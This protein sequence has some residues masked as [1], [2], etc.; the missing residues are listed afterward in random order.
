MQ[1]IKT[2]NLIS[3]F[4]LLIPFFVLSQIKAI[5]SL[6]LELAL[7]IQKDSLRVN[8]LNNISDLTYKKDFDK[9]I[10]FTNESEAISKAIDYKKGEARSLHIRGLAHII[11]SKY[12]NGGEY[13]MEAL[14]LYKLINYKKG[15]SIV[16]NHLGVYYY[17]KRDFKEAIKYYSEFVKISKE[18]GND[19]SVIVGKLFIGRSYNEIGNYIDAIK[20]YKEALSLSKATNNK[21]RISHSLTSIG[22]VYSHQ[23]NYPLALE[24]HN[25][26]LNIAKKSENHNAICA[27]LMS[28]GNVYIRVENYD[29]AIVYHKEALKMASEHDKQN[30][31]S[32]FNN[33]GEAYMNKKN[34]KQARTYFEKALIK[35]KA[36]NN[37]PNIAI[38]LNN[39]GSIYLEQK[40]F[41]VANK[42]FEEAK[43][44]CLEVDNQRGLCSSY[45]GI[46]RVYSNQKKYNLALTNALKSKEIS[47]N[48][49]L[50]DYQRDAE[51]LLYDIYFKSSK[52]KK[53]LTSHMQFKTL[54]DSL[55]NKEN[56]EKIAQLEYEYKY[57]QALDSASIRELKLTKTVKSTTQDLEKSQR[58]LLLG[59]IGF[60]ALTLL[61]GTFIFFLKLRHEKSKTQNIAIEQKLLRSQMTPHFIFN[62]LSVLQGMILNKEEDKSVYYLSKFSKLLRITLE[63]SRDKM[64]PLHQELGAVSSYL[65]LQNLEESQAYQYTVLVED[66]IDTELFKIPPMLIQP[67]IENAIEHGFKNQKENRKIDLL[68]KY[69]D[70]KLI[71]TITDN[72]V[73]INS[74]VTKEN[75]L[76]KS[77]ATTITSERL[78]ML[79]K[80]F[81][82][83]GNIRI[84]DR[85]NH[86]QKGTIVTITIPHK[87]EEA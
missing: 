9:T 77:L 83:E 68:L 64:V 59:V 41:E 26:A 50:L 49:K 55:F 8:L 85:L 45:I 28:I 46:A 11:K 17:N 7:H 10:A 60:L 20:F 57:K 75:G 23:G 81:N 78:K 36:K 12:T 37:K 67:F 74:Q 70:K 82:S 76:K 27:S 63:N 32:I 1:N 2:S 43:N 6:K 22:N 44:I 35:F 39:I 72:G 84:E 47:T 34:Y 80:D 56:V 13:L 87:I 19:K 53:A 30:E 58:N 62:S 24:Y 31:G 40:D 51:E 54:N 42:Y 52:Y 15:I 18:I 73:G 66:N 14:E 33:L 16:F 29:K 79:S 38:C 69:I 25:K 71:C 4:F 5:D 61:L 21:K 65:E 48:I 3:F 86:N